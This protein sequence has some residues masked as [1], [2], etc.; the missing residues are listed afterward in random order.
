M[1]AEKVLDFLSQL[2]KDG[3]E[4]KSVAFM[5]LFSVNWLTKNKFSA[6]SSGSFSNISSLTSAV[7][8]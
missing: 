8:L 3:R 5:F 2:V 6:S 1:Y 7:L 4:N